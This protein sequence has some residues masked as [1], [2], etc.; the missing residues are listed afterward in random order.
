VRENWKWIK[1]YWVKVIFITLGVILAL[2]VPPLVVHWMFKTPAKT[3]FFE[4][5]WGP[6]DLITYIAGFEAFAGTVFLGITAVKQNKRNIDINDRLL[7]VEETSSK[8]QRYPNYRV[9]KC[10]IE[11]TSIRKI[12]DLSIVIFFNNKLTK[13]QICSP[14][15]I[16]LQ[17]HRFLF[18]IE[19]ISDFNVTL[20]MI[21]LTLISLPEANIEVDYNIIAL[22][23]IDQYFTLA[24]KQ[25]LPLS[26]MIYDTDLKEQPSHQVNMKLLVKNN[27][28]EEFI[29][30]LRFVLQVTEKTNI[31]KLIS[32]QISHV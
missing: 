32:E 7:R 19:N 31:F 25:E 27:L 14:E 11:Q 21:S 29:L 17:F 22:V 18:N 16:D 20:S 3:P 2:I 26:F 12:Q 1:A 8:F 24:A 6:G 5:T 10:F 13:E 9:T 30:S 28:N 4:N 15:C 23:N